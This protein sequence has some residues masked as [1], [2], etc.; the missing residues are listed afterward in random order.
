MNGEILRCKRGYRKSFPPDSDKKC[1]DRSSDAKQAH[2][3]HYFF[4][5]AYVGDD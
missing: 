1:R 2:L 3:F 4:F 5:F